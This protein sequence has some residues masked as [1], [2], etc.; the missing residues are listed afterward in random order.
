MADPRKP[1]S[2]NP[3]D[4]AIGLKRALKDEPELTVQDLVAA[5]GDIPE[6]LIVEVL[7]EYDGSLPKPVR[8]GPGQGGNWIA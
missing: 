1:A 4:V 6:E 8:I 3:D 2:D 5:W 7:D